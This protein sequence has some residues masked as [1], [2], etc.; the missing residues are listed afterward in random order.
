MLAL[1]FEHQLNWSK[2]RSTAMFHVFI[3]FSYLTSAFGGML[4]DSGLGKYKTILYLSLVYVSGSVILAVTSI[5]GVT[6][7]PPHWWGSALGLLLIAIG[8]GGIKVSDTT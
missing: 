5:H 8:T 6:G 1:F 3:M 2:H 7:T 4:A